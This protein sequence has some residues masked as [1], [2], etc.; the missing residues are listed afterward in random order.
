M[1]ES[2]FSMKQEII[3]SGKKIII[4]IINGHL[5]VG[6]KE[7]YKNLIIKAQNKYF[8]EYEELKGISHFSTKDFVLSLFQTKV[9]KV[10]CGR[11]V[12]NWK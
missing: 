8:D 7:V 4:E 1:L 3:V 10:Y 5:F 9:L 12:N 6:G 11:V 2:T